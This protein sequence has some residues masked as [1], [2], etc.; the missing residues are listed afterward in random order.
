M[1]AIML[2]LAAVAV[3]VSDKMDSS[4]ELSL[5]TNTYV[6][7]RE[8]D[9]SFLHPE[10]GRDNWSRF[11]P[12]LDKVVENQG[13]VAEKEMRAAEAEIVSRFTLYSF[14]CEY[15]D[16]PVKANFD[17]RLESVR[18]LCRL[19]LV[20]S[21]TNTLYA[22]AEWL[23]GAAPLTADF[24]S[25]SN[26]MAEA[27]ARD[28]LMIYGGKW[29]PRYPGSVGNKRHW[30]PSARACDAK[31]RFRRLYNERLPKFRVAALTSFRKAVVDGYGGMTDEQCES[32]W[33]EVCRKAKATDEERSAA[34]MAVQ[35]KRNEP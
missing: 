19:S 20:R 18:L 35:A 12:L 10:S 11:V 17:G 29:P 14:A 30:G 26:E 1:N 22:V 31:F 7:L 25:C 8:I 6:A 32:I 21:D 27:F 13:R 2:A 24:K 15:D 16:D 34:E 9:D 28:R 3:A 33:L 5:G 4:S 23:S